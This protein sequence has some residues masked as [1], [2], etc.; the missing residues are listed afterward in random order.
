MSLYNINGTPFDTTDDI[1][2]ATSGNLFADKTQAD[3]SGDYG[4]PAMPA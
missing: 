2:V 3:Y 1:Q 4:T